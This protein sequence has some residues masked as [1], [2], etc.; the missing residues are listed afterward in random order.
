MLRDSAL[1]KN[2]KEGRNVAVFVEFSS[3]VKGQDVHVVT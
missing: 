2:L 1:K 3:I